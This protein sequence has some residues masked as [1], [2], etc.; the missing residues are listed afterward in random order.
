MT[1]DFRITQEFGNEEPLNP[2][3]A[4]EIFRNIT[5]HLDWLLST[6]KKWYEQGYTRKQASLY[7]VFI[8]GEISKPTLQR[9]EKEYKKKPL[10]WTV[11]IWDGESDEKSA[12]I[13]FYPSHS[14]TEKRSNPLTLVITF[15]VNQKLR[16]LNVDGALRLATLLVNLNRNCTYLNIES[17][18]Y[19]FPVISTENGINKIIYNK[20]FP[21]RI[22]C[23]WMLYI[24]N[25]VLTELIPEAARV[26]P[27]MDNGRQ[28]GTII[29][30]TEELFDGENEEHI[31]KSNDI[32]IKLLDLGFLPLMTEL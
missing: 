13:D 28:R 10:N 8:N 32:E 1:L 23:G 26:I 12:G 6:D 7:Q 21:E 31:A 11:G 14:S 17:R 19:S 24:P 18:G 16:Y 27:V 4:Y 5:L 22:S 30:S 29:V 20:V 9:W 15:R 3:Q 25:A 2:L